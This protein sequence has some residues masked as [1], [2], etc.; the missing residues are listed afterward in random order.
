MQEHLQASLVDLA[1]IRGG[2]AK[3]AACTHLHRPEA[4]IQ[5]PRVVSS[6]SLNNVPDDVRKGQVR[7][8]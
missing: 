6:C 2:S 7:R 5:N 8:S 3:L 4:S 1:D